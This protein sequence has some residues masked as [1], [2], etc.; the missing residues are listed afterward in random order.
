MGKYQYKCLA[1]AG[2]TDR[3]YNVDVCGPHRMIPNDC[4]DLSRFIWCHNQANTSTWPTFAG[5][6]QVLIYLSPAAGRNCQH[7]I[8]DISGYKEM[9]EIHFG[10]QGGKTIKK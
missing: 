5:N 3:K 7:C 4:D 1:A 2:K 10:C 8:Q 9:C 6:Y